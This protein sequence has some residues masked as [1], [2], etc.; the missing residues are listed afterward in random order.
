MWLCERQSFQVIRL[1]MCIYIIYQIKRIG[2]VEWESQPWE[3]VCF[4]NYNFFAP[5]LPAAMVGMLGC[6]IVR[7]Q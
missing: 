5:L 3:V 1:V 2:K 6:E 4:L 7:V